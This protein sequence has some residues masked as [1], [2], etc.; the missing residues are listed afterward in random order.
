MN[1]PRLLVLSHRL[2]FP[3]HNGAAI[4]SWHLF[5]ELANDFDITALCFDRTDPALVAMPVAERV[6]GLDFC[7][8]VDVF[9][10]EQQH[11][12]RRLVADHLESIA[13]GLPY[14][15]AMHRSARFETALQRELATGRFDLVHV[16]SLDL[17]RLLPHLAGLQVV[18][19]HHNAES[20]LLKRRAGRE[21]GPRS[22]YIRHQAALLARSER[23]VL[24]RFRLNLV[25]SNEDRDLLRNL[26]PDARFEVLPNGVDTSFFQP[27]NY[28]TRAGAVFV[29]GTTWYPN[30]DGLEWYADTI[31][32]CMHRHGVHDPVTWVGRILDE[33]RRLFR[34]EGLHFTGYVDDIRP[35]VLGAGCFI[36]PLRVG[37]GTR[38]KLLDAWAMGMPVVATRAAAEGL[39]WRDGENMLVADGPEEFAGA[40]AR[41]LSDKALAARLGAAGRAE[42]EANYSWS[43]VGGRLRTLYQGLLT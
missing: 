31:H 41:V 32:P 36:A 6:R 26:A 8:R 10:I 3:P 40:V 23:Q 4:R 2:P 37:G 33:E 43:T 42:V 39:N 19:N 34:R 35:H 15:H 11:S 25:V 17:I 27:L 9:P 14:V 1:R 21:R 22:W 13:S 5:R 12:R 20:T 24:A 38:L 30:R 18:C 16:D 29:G 7:R 28:P